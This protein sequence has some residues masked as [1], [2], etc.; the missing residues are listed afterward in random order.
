MGNDMHTVGLFR[1]WFGYLGGAAA[2]SVFHLVSYL[3]ASTMCGTSAEILL[4]STTAATAAVT[5]AATWVCYTNWKRLRDLQ[6]ESPGVFR[7]MLL[8]GVYMNILF[9]LTIIVSGVAVFML[10]PCG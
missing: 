4:H 5:A 1:L 9:L 2:W 6:P 3:W 7:Y 10:E 8:S